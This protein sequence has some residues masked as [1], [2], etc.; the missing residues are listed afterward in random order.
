M[1]ENRLMPLAWDTVMGLNFPWLSWIF[2]ITSYNVTW[3]W[4]RENSKIWEKNKS[5]INL[6]Y[7]LGKVTIPFG[8]LFLSSVEKQ[9]LDRSALLN[10]S[11]NLLI[12]AIHLLT[13]TYDSWSTEILVLKAFL[14]LCQIRDHG[15]IR[16][17]ENNVP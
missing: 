11:A 5:E 2:W 7:D 17:N 8:E 1:Y 14:L 15:G 10:L 6:L 13:I 12:K 16:K 4:K 3:R 9:A